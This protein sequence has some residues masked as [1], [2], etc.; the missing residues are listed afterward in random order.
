[1]SRTDDVPIRVVLLVGMMG[2]GKSSVGRATARLLGWPYLDNDEQ[3]RERS[4]SAAPDVATKLGI[5][6]LHRLERAALEAT[7]QH[8]GPLVASAA[9]TVVDDGAWREQHGQDVLVVWLR[10]R[11]ETLL[12]R[13]GAGASRR[14]D[15]TSATW[16][17]ST[18]ARREPALA[19]LADLVIDVDERSVDQCAAALVAMIDG[20]GRG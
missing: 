14:A 16:T 11:P 1:V 15:A 13:V 20:R 7:L 19:A 17:R 10:A 12:A 9:G 4:G 8:P 18:L 5:E 2:A 6:E 3:V